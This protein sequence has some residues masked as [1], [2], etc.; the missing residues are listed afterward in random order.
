MSGV[1]G[2][3]SRAVVS[4]T[5]SWRWVGLAV[6]VSSSML[7][8]HSRRGHYLVAIVYVVA[9]M[10]RRFH[11]REG[12]VRNLALLT[13]VTGTAAKTELSA[14]QLVQVIT[15]PQLSIGVGELIVHEYEEKRE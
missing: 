15:H 8:V 12:R 2:I 6:V 13:G 9:I 7:V 4:N 3:S 1:F 10:V 5:I 14:S 11:G